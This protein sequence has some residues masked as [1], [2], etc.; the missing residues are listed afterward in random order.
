ME[1]LLHLIDEGILEIKV[2][3][4][5]W[6]QLMFED[7]I[8]IVKRRCVLRRHS[9]TIVPSTDVPPRGCSPLDGYINPFA[10]ETL[11]FLN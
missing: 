4:T 1:N 9:V 8:R 5:L 6:Y 10:T 7:K 11:C 2:G 3:T